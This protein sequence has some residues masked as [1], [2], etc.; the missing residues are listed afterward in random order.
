[1]AFW[2]LPALMQEVQTSMRLGAPLTRARTRWMFGFQRR[3]VR[4][5]E[6]L[7]FIPNDGFLPH[8]LQTAAMTTYTPQDPVGKRLT[9]IPAELARATISPRARPLA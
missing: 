8:T 9:T 2:I 6:W 4:R 7:T 5:W 3:F 1:V